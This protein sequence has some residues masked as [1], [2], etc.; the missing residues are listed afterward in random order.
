MALEHAPSRH[1]LNYLHL[2]SLAQ[3]PVYSLYGLLCACHYRP[4]TLVL[5]NRPVPL[6]Y[7]PKQVLERRLFKILGIPSN[8]KLCHRC[9]S[10][11]STPVECHH[12]PQD[13]YS[14]RPLPQQPGCR[15]QTTEGPATSTECFCQ[16]LHNPTRDPHFGILPP[17][18][19]YL[20]CPNHPPP[21]ILDAIHVLVSRTAASGAPKPWKMVGRMEHNMGPCK[22]RKLGSVSSPGM[23]SKS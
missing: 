1:S 8:T 7:H 9:T 11:A 6:L 23:R 12:P 4:A 15:G 18:P 19:L 5:P 13:Y 20:T 3:S 21:R 16:S 17:H 22:Y 14:R 2:P 10:I